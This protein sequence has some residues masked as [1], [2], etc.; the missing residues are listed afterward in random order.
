MNTPDGPRAVI[1]DL[2]GVLVDSE[3]LHVKAWKVLFEREGIRACEEEFAMGVGMADTEWISL[4]LAA[5]RRHDDPQWWR[6]AKNEVF[7]EIL[8]REVRPFP[9]ALDLIERL[10]GEFRLG[11]ASNSVRET[12]ETALRVLGVRERFE[13]VVGAEDLT[14]YKPHPEAYLKAA[15]ALGVAPPRCTVVEDS[16]LG[17]QA[18]KAAGMRCVAIT[19]TLPAHRLAQADLI[20]PSLEEADALVAFARGEG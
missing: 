7:R 6:R 16:T 12:V 17:V 4:I 3:P 11:V 20:L 9:G 10:R 15:G 13:A 14:N 2:D 5:R 18:A 8:I 19:T 1:F